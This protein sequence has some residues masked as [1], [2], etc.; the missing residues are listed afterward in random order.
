MNPIAAAL[1]TSLNWYDFAVGAAVLLGFFSGLRAGLI[2]SALRVGTWVL[3]TVLALAFY[4]TLGMWMHDIM[5]VETDSAN[6]Q[7]F[8]IVALVVFVLCHFASNEI[9]FRTSK[10]GLPAW[11]DNA[12]GVLFGAVLMVLVMAWLSIVLALMRSPFWHE[13]I[14][15]N[16]CFGARVV[17]QFPP[18][19][20]M[21][22]KEQPEKL[23][24]MKPIPRRAEPTPDT[25]GPR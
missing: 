3:M 6:L 22:E 10:Y 15:R 8:L 13:Q 11:L 23:W 2:R 9:M 19:A 21:A 20:A 14:A 16:S 4:V 17:Q 7:A 18:V 5:G 1:P 24:F 12:G 25:K